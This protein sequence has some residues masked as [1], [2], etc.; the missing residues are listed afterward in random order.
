MKI[1]KLTSLVFVIVLLLVTSMPAGAVTDGT[2]D[3][4]GHP[5]VGIMVAFDEF[6]NG[7]RCSGTLLSPTVFLTAGH[8]TDGAVGKVQLWFD[9]DVQSGIPGNGWPLHGEYTG[10]A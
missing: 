8:C 1:F 9:A 5:Y 2:P 10:T 6:G 7:W 3:G 4:D